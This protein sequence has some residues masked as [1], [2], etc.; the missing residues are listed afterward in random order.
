MDVNGMTFAREDADELKGLLSSGRGRGGDAL[1]LFEARARRAP[2]LEPDA[3]AGTAD[4]PGELAR[5]PAQARAHR[6]RRDDG[7]DRHAAGEHQRGRDVQ[8]PARPALSPPPRE[9][10]R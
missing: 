4:A 9:R 3:D 8:H 2:H 7:A 6:V 5:A 1:L 10:C